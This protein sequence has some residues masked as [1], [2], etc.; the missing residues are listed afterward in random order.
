MRRVRVTIFTLENST[1]ITYSECAS[2]TLVMQHAV[3]MRCMVMCGVSDSHIFPH[4]LINGTI[5]EKKVYC[6]IFST[7]FV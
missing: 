5:F 7:T 4:Y 6:V 3:R 2:V 1:R